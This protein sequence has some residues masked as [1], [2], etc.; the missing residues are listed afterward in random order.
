MPTTP[1]IQL[2]ILNP[3]VLN[4]KPTNTESPSAEA[5]DG[6]LLKVM[7]DVFNAAK[8]SLAVAAANPDAE[9][10]AGTLEGDFQ[11]ALQSVKEELSGPAKLKALELIN[12][13]VKLRESVF[14]RYGELPA[15][16]ALDRGFTQLSDELPTLQVNYELLGLT[17]PQLSVPIS[18][19]SPTDGGLLI[20]AESL[21]VNL[22]DLQ[23]KMQA[24][25]VRAVDS[26][27]LNMERFS[28]VWG[29][30]HEGDLYS[31]VDGPDDNFQAQSTTDK[32]GLYIRKI[33]CED[34]TDWEWPFDDSIALAG[35]STDETGD[36]KK[37]GE[38]FIGDGFHD[39]KEKNYS[40][41]QFH[42]FSLREGNHW[43]KKY[44]VTFILAEK[45]FGG[46]A[47]F[48]GSIYDKVKVQVKAA[49]EKVFAAGGAAVGSI[50]GVATIGAA[51]GRAIGMAV[52]WVVDKL[53][54]W[55]RSL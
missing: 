42:Y 22:E 31:V 29:E 40:D 54:G 13:P 39:G 46:L 26:G 33:K 3:G 10:Q 16:V 43:P 23:S 50:F 30:V 35:I 27:V 48:I 8:Y 36:V 15:E 24:S 18:E 4:I 7:E 20:P 32:L 25:E 51:I 17:T 38:H 53:V 21:P 28:E 2:D 52:G 44:G 45:D 14:G 6:E 41:W 37:I 49:I 55:I 11:T 9:L 5:P 34:E 12:A 1:E 19:F 47:K